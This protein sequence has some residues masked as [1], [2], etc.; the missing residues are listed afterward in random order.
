MCPAA[1]K[2]LWSCVDH[3]DVSVFKCELLCPEGECEIF[4]F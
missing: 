4:R 3:R 2:S 1:K